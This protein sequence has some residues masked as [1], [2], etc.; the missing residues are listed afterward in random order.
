MKKLLIFK[1]PN[2]DIRLSI[3]TAAKCIITRDNFIKLGF[4]KLRDSSDLIN[5]VFN[6]FNHFVDIGAFVQLKE[7]MGI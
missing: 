2:E 3:C 5:S 6:L 7:K 1:P 4:I